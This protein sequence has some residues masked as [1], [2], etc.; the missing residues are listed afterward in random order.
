MLKPFSVYEYYEEYFIEGYDYRDYFLF[1]YSGHEII[2]FKSYFYQIDI[3]IMFMKYI[4]NTGVID[5]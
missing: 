4:D 1:V 3:P 2:D 5:Y